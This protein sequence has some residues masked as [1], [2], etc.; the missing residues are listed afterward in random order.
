VSGATGPILSA[1]NFG[2]TFAGRT[3]LRGIDLDVRPGEIHGLVG[4]N[5]SGKSTF[6]KI[7]SGFHTPDAGASLAVQGETVALPL[8]P[9]DP[10]RL[11]F[12]FMHQD[13]GLFESATVLEN[14]RVGRYRTGLGWRISWRSEREAARLALR[15]FGVEID[16]DMPVSALSEIERAVI[17][18][19]R[20]LDQLD[21][22]RT[23]LLVLDEPT[24]YLPKENAETLFE[25]MRRI[26]AEGF[27]V[28]FVSHRLAE[29]RSI[30][31]RITILRNGTLV[32]T[33]DAASLGEQALIARI[34]GF[35]LEELY[36]E[37][38]ESNRGLALSVR[39]LS[40]QSVD[41]LSLDVRSGEIV[42][43][44]G[45][46]GMGQEHIPY[47]LFGAA[48]ADAGT[49]VVGGRSHDL[50]RLTPQQAICAGLALLPGSRLR[51]GGVLNATAA[52][53]MTLATLPRYFVR[54]L[55]RHRREEAAVETLM[56]QFQ[57]QPVEAERQFATF[58]GGNQQ[59]IL[60]AK[61][62]AGEPQVFL[63]H[64]P[65]HGVD[66]GAKRQIF[67]HIRNAAAKGASVVISSVE[68]ED[69]AHLCDRV[70]VFRDGRVVSELHGAE[71][72][73][74]RILEQCLRASPLPPDALA[75]ATP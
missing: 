28:I 39:G 31:D 71:L 22:G 30:C 45:L 41:T 44:T 57:V 73:H 63:L 68:Y 37:V 35:S 51:D 13:L 61:W 21:A 15:R 75:G 70:F 23:G 43:L 12:A 62:F 16:P 11:N 72:T 4:Q 60:L 6:I 64:E 27:G 8:G 33:A 26:A 47:L 34:L 25:A 67:E 59:K 65:A 66:I 38:A 5:G 20:A 42:G 9:S 32:D 29:V 14:L 58:S 52:E 36:P 55:L 17:A 74:E 40:S 54:G 49:L 56:R 3:V 19:V 1:K 48:R 53:N 18:I 46:L 50:A 10:A 24:A 7:L 2:K 69:L